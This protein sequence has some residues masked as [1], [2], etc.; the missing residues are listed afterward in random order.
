MRTI[1]FI[2][3]VPNPRNRII[4][5][6]D[7]YAR[8]HGTT[9]PPLHRWSDKF[10][11]WPSPI[12]APYSI[13]YHLL[14]ALGKHA[15]VKLYDWTENTTCDMKD[16][17]IL[18][19]HPH[20]D[21]KKE[22]WTKPDDQSVMWKTIQKYPRNE[23]YV[24][25]P[26]N[27]DPRQCEW[28]KG[29]FKLVPNFIAIC[30]KNWIDSWDKSPLFGV[31][32]N[33]KQVDM[34]IDIANYP[35]VKKKFNK[36]GQRKFLYIGNTYYM[37]NTGQL[38]KI[39]ALGKNF[40]GGYISK[41]EISGWKKIA[42]HANLTPEYMSKIADEYDVFINCSTFDAQATTVIENMCFGLAIACTPESGY[43]Y[44][45][46][47]KLDCHDT[48]FNLEQINKIQNMEEEELVSLADANRK[49]AEEK[50]T[51]DNFC[52]NVIN[53]IKI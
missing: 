41:G 15:K 2:Y 20:P 31:V 27:H 45:S 46:I 16:G 38:E 7:T 37:K 35:R 43:S 52:K 3:T 6:A 48:A 1:H 13:T 30:G 25:A 14:K 53:F 49:I 34:A 11:N 23:K 33:L 22:L 39:A 32:K 36:K 18:L 5:R 8:K 47:I 4:K 21:T 10:I 40:Q 29:V 12:Y 19:G 17:D 42:S 24:I 50:H 26:Y 44:P 28:V 9:I 51:W